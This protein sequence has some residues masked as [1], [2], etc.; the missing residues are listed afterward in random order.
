M[1]LWTEV[2]RR[3]LTGEISRRQACAQYEL[4]WQTL[5]KIL[6][7]VEPP[8]YRRATSRSRPKME[9]FLPLIA[10]ILVSDAKARSATAAIVES[11]Q[12]GFV[13]SPH[14]TLADATSQPDCHRHRWSHPAFETKNDDPHPPR[15]VGVLLDPL[16]TP[17]LR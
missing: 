10:E 13:V 17:Q 16:Q 11:R 7:H 3:V 9:R 2:R 1:E 8:G 4:H 5:Q 15:P 14:P 12:A 6:G